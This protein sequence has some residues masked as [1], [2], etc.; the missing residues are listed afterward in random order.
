MTKVIDWNN[1]G[2]K[3]KAIKNIVNKTYDEKTGTIKLNLLMDELQ[4]A[5]LFKYMLNK[6]K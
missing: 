5:G 3:N 2:A 4:E 1:K 6:N